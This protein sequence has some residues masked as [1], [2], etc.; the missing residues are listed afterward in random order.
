MTTEL[1]KVAKAIQPSATLSL[2]SEISRVESTYGVKIVDLTAGQP[3]MGPTPDVLQ[4][5]ADG[6]KL[7]KYGPIPGEA[8]L[9]PLL[10]EVTSR[11]TG[12]TFTADQ[13]VVT[14]GAK[15]AID[16]VMRAILDPDDAVAIMAPYWVTYPEVVAINGGKPVFVE[17]TSDLRPDLP[18]LEAAVANHPTKA[19]L[20]SSPSNPTGVVY[21]RQE[22]DAIAAIARK[23]DVWLIADEIYREFSFSGEPA[24]SLFAAADAY[25]KAILVDG[26][27]KRFGVPGWRLGF[28]AGPL[29]I[30]KAISRI[31]SHTANPSRPIQAAA[32]VAYDSELAKAATANMV[33]RYMKNRDLFVEG[34]NRIAGVKCPTPDGAFYCF[35]DVSG[36]YGKK[37]EFEGADVEIKNSTDFRNFLLRK[38]NVAAVEGGPFGMDTH[39]RFSMAV[40]T[41]DCVNAVE[42]I[43]GAVALLK[44]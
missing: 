29:E 9:R 4:A 42:K 23:F 30:A 34:M 44:S 5:L 18:R 38:A 43:T 40:A 39:M 22:L 7:F 28:V 37:Y 26:P 19:I 24:P 2:K 20:Y 16:C 6:G 21:T 15:G 32:Q 27:S 31:Q 12:T 3:D 41:N 14:V 25:D 33:A 8:G 10:A 11:E 13:V 17:P 1:S 35:P 36:L